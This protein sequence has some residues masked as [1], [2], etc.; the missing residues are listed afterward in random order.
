VPGAL[1]N[2]RP[3]YSQSDST[4]LLGKAEL[5]RNVIMPRHDASRAHCNIHLPSDQWSFISL[6]SVAGGHFS[7]GWLCR[8]SKLR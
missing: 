4:H 2:K 7:R 6:C 3:I 5:Y 1:K 8:I